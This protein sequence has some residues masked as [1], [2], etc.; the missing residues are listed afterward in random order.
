MTERGQT[1]PHNAERPMM[2]KTSTKPTRT[3]RQEKNES[4]SQ[5]VKRLSRKLAS[6]ELPREPAAAAKGSAAEVLY[7]R[8][9]E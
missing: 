9:I 6:E 2:K 8:I 4:F 1:F 3:R 5:Q 7:R